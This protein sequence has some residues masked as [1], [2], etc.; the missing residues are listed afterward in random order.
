MT[1]KQK[2]VLY[3]IIIAAAL[4]TALQFVPVQGYVR[5]ALY[6]IPYLVIGYDI[7]DRKSVV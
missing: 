6:L 7:L 4:M 3:R 5:F 2:K 1:K